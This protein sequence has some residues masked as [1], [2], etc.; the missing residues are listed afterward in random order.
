MRKKD[1]NTSKIYTRPP[2]GMSDPR[3]SCVVAIPF[4]I[5]ASLYHHVV[6]VKRPLSRERC[7]NRGACPP[8]MALLACLLSSHDVTLFGKFHNSLNGATKLFRASPH[9]PP[10]SGWLVTANGW[11]A[12]KRRCDGSCPVN[13]YIS[14]L[15]LTFIYILTQFQDE[16]HGGRGEWA[17]PCDDFG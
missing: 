6:R 11:A 16:L 1:K 3:F 9:P 2:F 4:R 13:V 7:G 15:V 5:N 17:Q 8:R 14:G 10:R 12:A